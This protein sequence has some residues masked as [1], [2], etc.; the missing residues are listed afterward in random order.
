MTRPTTI[1]RRLVPL[2]ALLLAG[3]TSRADY[4]ALEARYE[5][6]LA[7]N[8]QLQAEKA[9]LEAQQSAQNTYT[10]AADLLFAPRGFD[11]TPAGQAALNDILTKLR[12]LKNSKIV[13]YGYTD[14]RRTGP[15]L[16]KQGIATN[17]DL[18][19]KRADTVADYLHAH[20]VDPG[21][22]SAKGR[23]NT[24]PVASNAT[25]AG[26]ARNRRIEI[27]VEGPGT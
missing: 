13:V 19:S 14:D 24:H 20:G 25:G 21:I 16:R 22:L 26:R 11:I 9:A 7:A 6:A 5:Q 15:E 10:V 4:D 3:C 2:C 23:G 17:L 27:V 12:D 8:R 18:S 1:G